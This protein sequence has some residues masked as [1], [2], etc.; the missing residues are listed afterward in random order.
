MP[1]RFSVSSIWV[2][3]RLSSCGVKAASIFFAA[4]SAAALTSLRPLTTSWNIVGRTR[5]ES[6]WPQPGDA[7]TNLVPASRVSMKGFTKGWRCAAAAR[8][9]V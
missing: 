7:G 1:V 5:E 4:S 2:V 3:T 8:T 9:S 6:I